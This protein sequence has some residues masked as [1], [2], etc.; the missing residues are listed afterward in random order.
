MSH[1]SKITA[2]IKDLEVL[3][4]TVASMGYQLEENAECRYYYGTKHSDYVIKLPGEYDVAISKQDDSFSI[5]ADLW[6]GHVTK[7]VGQNAS[8]LVQNYTVEKIKAEA[9]KENLAILGTERQGENIALK[10][11]DPET[12]GLIEAVCSSAG[13]ISWQTSGFSGTGCMKFQ[14]LEKSLGTVEKTTFTSEYYAPEKET[15]IETVNEILT[16]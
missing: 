8:L 4:K 9:C 3:R 11:T 1:F 10:I 5:E 2:E 6:G 12:G 15:G 7:Y 16:E 13:E 14:N